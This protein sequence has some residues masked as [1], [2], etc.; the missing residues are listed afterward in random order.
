MLKKLV[1]PC[2]K[3]ILLQDKDVE[4]IFVFK[5]L[6]PFQAQTKDHTMWG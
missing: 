2:S 4:K 1:G 3:V 5:M 6:T